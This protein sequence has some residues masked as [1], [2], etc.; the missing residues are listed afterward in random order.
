M[1]FF[2]TFVTF[3]NLHEVRRLCHWGPIIALSVIAICSTMAIL[4]SIIWYW[5]LDTTG[6]S[7]N[8][9]MLINWT[10]LILYNYF[11]AM[12]V[13][14]GYIPL[15]WKPVRII[16]WD[17][18]AFVTG[19]FFCCCFFFKCRKCK[20]PVATISAKLPHK[21]LMS[22]ETIYLYERCCIRH[23]TYFFLSQNRR[24]NM[25]PGTYSTAKCA[26]GT[27]PPDPTIVAS[28][29]G[30]CIYYRSK[31]GCSPTCLRWS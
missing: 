29:T 1:N 31:R 30:S 27:R 23:L 11:N 19:V 12:F 17:N 6:G 4:D 10:V 3:E 13:G 28:V 24:I 5:P 16:T 9:I 18:T 20:E 25:M 26:K 14:P 15:C 2:S 8:F 7:I 22:S 21:D